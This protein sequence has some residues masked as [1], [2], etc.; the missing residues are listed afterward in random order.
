MPNS[1]HLYL[2]TS[3]SFIVPNDNLEFVHEIKHSTQKTGTTYAENRVNFLAGITKN[4]TI[5]NQADFI[6]L[7]LYRAINK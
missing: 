6:L 2:Q 7:L 4:S 5:L 1:F 3:Y